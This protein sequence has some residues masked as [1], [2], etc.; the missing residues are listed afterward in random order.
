MNDVNVRN[1]E[2][3]PRCDDLREFQEAFKQL[4]LSHPGQLKQPPF[5]LSKQLEENKIP[6]SD[7]LSVYQDN[8]LVSLTNVILDCFP[9]TKALVGEDFLRYAAK[10]YIQSHPPEQGCMN[11]YGS[12]LPSFLASFEPAK[13]LAYLPDMARFEVA[14]N[15]AYYAMEDPALT[16]AQLAA[17]P[18]ET[19]SEHT[20][21]LRASL[22]L[23]E[24]SYPLLALHDFVTKE[25]DPPSLEQP[26]TNWIMIYRPALDVEFLTLDEAEHY[27]LSGLQTANLGDALTATLDQ[28]PDFDLNARLDKHLRIGTFAETSVQTQLNE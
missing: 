18:Q 9:L 28:F 11:H 1:T 22:T 27:F 13:A 24:S 20:L 5:T 17:L 7:R 19:L 16:A 25:T 3:R 21:T 23:L 14:M 15:D 2:S 26:Q 10:S 8:I 6:L 4:M 12:N